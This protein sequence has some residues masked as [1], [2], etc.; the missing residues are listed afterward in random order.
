MQSMAEHYF[1]QGGH[2]GAHQVSVETTLNICTE[3][4]PNVEVNALRKRLEAITDLDRLK[5]L[6]LNAAIA[7]N[8]HVFQEAL[9]AD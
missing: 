7:E 8:F 2:Q 9:N 6:N 4:F 1:Q 5:K 3:R